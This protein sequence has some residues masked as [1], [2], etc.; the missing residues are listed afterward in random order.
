MCRLSGGILSRPSARVACDSCEAEAQPL[1]TVILCVTVLHVPAAAG[2]C[3]TVW[4]RHRA[5]PS[6]AEAAVPARLAQRRYRNIGLIEQIRCDLDR[7]EL[8]SNSRV[9][10]RSTLFVPFWFQGLI[11]MLQTRTANVRWCILDRQLLACCGMAQALNR[12]LHISRCS[13]NDG[14]I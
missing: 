10:E 3:G 9:K 14:G 1:L 2:V 6:A 13:G 12:L 5:R 7:F 11:V 8:D 4:R